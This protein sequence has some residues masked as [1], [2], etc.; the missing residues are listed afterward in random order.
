MLEVS[1]TSD[2]SGVKEENIII[3]TPTY[4]EADN[5]SLFL[6]KLFSLDLNLSVLVV[7]DNSP[8]G[9]HAEV[10]RLQAEYPN[11][12]LI[13]RKEKLGMGSAYIEGF[14]HALKEGYDI[15]V[16][17]DADLSHEPSCIPGM[18][19]LLKEYDMVIGSR[20]IKGGGVSNWALDRVLLSR[21]ANIFAKTLLGVPINDMTSGF[22]CIRAEVLEG[23]GFN[24]IALKGYAFQIEL[25]FRSWLGGFKIIEYPIIFQERKYERSKMSLAI[26]VEA[27]FRVISLSIK[28]LLQGC[29]KNDN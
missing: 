29:Y 26:T 24:N 22:K 25:I 18:L 7:D 20:Y 27:F 21:F 15:V 13:V 23:I 10:R 5:I 12:H 28:R 1:K 2:K 11:L 14:K 6:K 4:N 17:M 19:D 8:D 9:T 16:Q 3:I